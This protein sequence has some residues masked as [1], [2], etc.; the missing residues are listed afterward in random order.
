LLVKGL[1]Y[2]QAVEEDQPLTGHFG[3]LYSWYA[4]KAPE[5]DS[6]FFHDESVDLWSL[7]ALIY[8]SLTALPPFRGDG[9]D[10]IENK[11][12]GNVVFDMVIPSRSAQKLIT[13]LLQVDPRDRLTIEQ[14]LNSEW[15]IEAD[16]VLDGYDL[17]LAHSF[18]QDWSQRPGL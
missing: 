1:Q 10:L 16:D 3:Y 14:V 9:A 2:A 5:I 4:F 17:A 7:G 11:H 18:F 8:M 12:A 15:M 13:G 6:D